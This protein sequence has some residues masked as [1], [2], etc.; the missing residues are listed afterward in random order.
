METDVRAT[1]VQSR[2]SSPCVVCR[3][4][5]PA[6]SQFCWRPPKIWLPPDECLAFF[7][8]S[9][10]HPVKGGSS[11]LRA[12]SHHKAHR[13]RR[14]CLS[15][16]SKGGGRLFATHLGH[17]PY[18]RR[19]ARAR[20]SAAAPRARVAKALGGEMNEA[21]E[22]APALSR[23]ASAGGKLMLVVRHC[24]GLLISVPGPTQPLASVLC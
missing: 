11:T 7:G 4:T 14:N 8:S 9:C 15:R 1:S 18:T 16:S 3:A 20:N 13:G 23:G 21:T 5:W 17:R 6:S 2:G 10:R 12:A 19:L 24:A 22:A